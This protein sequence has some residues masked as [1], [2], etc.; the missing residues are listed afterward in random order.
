VCFLLALHCSDSLTRTGMIEV[1]DPTKHYSILAAIEDVSF[2]VDEDEILGFPEP[3]AAGR[4][5]TMRILTAFMPQNS[6]TV[7]VAGFDVFSDSL[8][9]RKRIGCSECAEPG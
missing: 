1:R 2:T 4:T 5:A 6:G 7:F 8:E 9:V 3:D